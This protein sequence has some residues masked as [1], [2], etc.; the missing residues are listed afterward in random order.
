MYVLVFITT[1]QVG[2]E[3]SYRLIAPHLKTSLTSGSNAGGGGGGYYGGGG[4][5]DIGTGGGGS[6][7]VSLEL[8]QRVLYS[9]NIEFKS[10]TGKNEIGHSGDG[11]A[12][13]TPLTFIT[14][15]CFRHSS[16]LFT[17]LFILCS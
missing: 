13:I 6:G 2:I 1:L 9:G 5:A 17:T 8:R 14:R 16:F 11:F 10:P 4:G 15:H 3:G 7:Y 12:R